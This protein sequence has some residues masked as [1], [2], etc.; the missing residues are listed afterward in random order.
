MRKLL[1]PVYILHWVFYKVY[2]REGE[3]P[4][5]FSSIII[6]ALLYLANINSVW[7]LFCVSNPSE[8]ESQFI[9]DNP[10]MSVFDLR[11]ILHFAPYVLVPTAIIYFFMFYEYDWKTLFDSF[12]KEFRNKRSHIIGVVSYVVFSIILFAIALHS[13]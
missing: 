9:R 6:P 12:E 13:L 4:A 3:V 7:V 2:L 8:A 5:L 1:K 11:G 10:E